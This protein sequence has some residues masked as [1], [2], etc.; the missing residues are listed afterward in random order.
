MN[1]ERRLLA[2]HIFPGAELD[3][4]RLMVQSMESGGF[5][6]SDVEGWRNHYIRHAE[7]GASDCTN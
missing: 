2:K 3:P 1:S 7:C 6:I 4:L 5:E